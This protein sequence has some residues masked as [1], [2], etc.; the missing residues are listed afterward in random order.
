M[1][2]R[3]MSVA[4][5]CGRVGASI[6]KSRNSTSADIE[7]IVIPNDVIAV[8]AIMLMPDKFFDV[9]LEAQANSIVPH[10]PSKAPNPNLV[11]FRSKP[12]AN[13]PPKNTHTSPIKNQF[14]IFRLSKSNSKPTPANGIIAT[15]KAAT[16]G[17]VKYCVIRSKMDPIPNPKKPIQKPK[18]IQIFQ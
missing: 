12:R 1:K 3:N 11:S 9:F 5:I 8:F 17:F 4:K 15:V 7:K 14:V 16:T 10:I 13:K 18:K 2:I 6:L